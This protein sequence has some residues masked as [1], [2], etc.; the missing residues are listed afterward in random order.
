[1]CRLLLGLLG[2]G[3]EGLFLEGGVV[4]S[5]RDFLLL[6]A[7]FSMLFLHVNPRKMVLCSMYYVFAASPGCSLFFWC[8]LISVVTYAFVL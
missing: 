5:M 2:V 4:S 8:I 1:M 7:F 6:Q 3:R